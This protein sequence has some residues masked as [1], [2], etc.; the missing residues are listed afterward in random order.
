MA[1]TGRLIASI[2]GKNSN[3]IGG[4]GGKMNYFP[5]S[6]T[7]FYSE[8]NTFGSVTTNSVIV[9]LPQNNQVTPDKFYAVETPAQLVTNGS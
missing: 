5:S 9:L 6:Q 7:Y 8:I 1:L 4:A 3:A 2:Y